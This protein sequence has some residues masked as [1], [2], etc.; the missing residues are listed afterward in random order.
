M[1][2][3][4]VAIMGSFPRRTLGF[5]PKVFYR[6]GLAITAKAFLADRQGGR[7]KR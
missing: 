2:N 7:A 1:Q 3:S 6:E 5:E 4:G